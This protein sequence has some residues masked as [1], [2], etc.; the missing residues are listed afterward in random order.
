GVMVAHMSIP[1]LDR[2]RNLPSS[3]SRPIVTDL[4]KNRLGFRGLT[5]T[6][7]M[8]MNGV[9]KHFRNGEADVRAIIAGND[10]LELSQNSARAIN[11]VLAAIK[12]G[13]LSQQDID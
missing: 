8:D 1:S 11:M 10:L 2:T 12:Q 6:D 13:R 5:F 7:A 9:V 3:L 4:L